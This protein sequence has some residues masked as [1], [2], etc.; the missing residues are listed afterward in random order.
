MKTQPAVAGFEVG[1]RGPGVQERGW[2]YVNFQKYSCVT[3]ACIFFLPFI[4]QKLEFKKNL[5][6]YIP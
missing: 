1:E 3:N 2:P 5:Y 6:F 4:L